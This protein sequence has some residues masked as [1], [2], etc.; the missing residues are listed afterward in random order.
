[1]I[2]KQNE[3]HSYCS[4]GQYLRISMPAIAVP[5]MEKANVFPDS[6]LAYL[7]SGIIS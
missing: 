1:M 6:S 3:K 5:F 7:S 2:K 4:L